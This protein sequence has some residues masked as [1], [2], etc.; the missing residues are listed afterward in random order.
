MLTYNSMTAYRFTYTPLTPKTAALT[1]KQTI[2]HAKDLAHAQLDTEAFIKLTL[3]HLYH[4]DIVEIEYSL[5]QNFYGVVVIAKEIKQRITV[6]SGELHVYT[7]T[8]APEPLEVEEPTPETSEVS[9]LKKGD[10]L[11]KV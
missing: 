5:E 2:F 1:T 10:G 4:P 9:D 6:L 11:P 7:E 8:R 3:G